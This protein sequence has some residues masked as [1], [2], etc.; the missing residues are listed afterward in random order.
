[1]HAQN[2]PHQYV[3]SSSPPLSMSSMPSSK[4]ASSIPPPSLNISSSSERPASSSSS[5]SASSSS[6]SASSSPSASPASPS[7][8]LNLEDLGW[9]LP[10]FASRFS[11]LRSRRI[12]ALL[13]DSCDPASDAASLSLSEPSPSAS[14]WPSSVS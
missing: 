6:S 2:T 12:S 11:R 5:S 13:A 3:G 10:L 4:P 9:P 1:M 7:P 8:W 14:V